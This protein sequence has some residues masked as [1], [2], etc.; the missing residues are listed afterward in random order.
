MPAVPT[1][2]PVANAWLRGFINSNLPGYAKVDVGGAERTATSA[3]DDEP[4]DTWVDTKLESAITGDGWA[5]SIDTSGRVTLSGTS[6]EIIWPDRLGWLM[7][8]DAEPGDSEGT[9]TSITSRFV[10]PGQIPLL[11]AKPL[12]MVSDREVTLEID[13]RMRP[14]A[15]VFGT[16]N[17][18][19]YLLTMTRWA[20]D[21]LITGWCLRGGVEIDFGDAS[22]FSSTNPDGLVSGWVIGIES[23]NHI[24]PS[25]MVNRPVE[26]VLLL[27][28]GGA[29][30]AAKGG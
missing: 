3:K 4:F 23:A 9:V 6:A 16:S 22:V 25:G 8:F 11:G 27:A 28:H 2:W 14:H 7:G 17:V 15:S 26:V 20:Y 5:T 19:R 24:G 21:A 10:P 12:D 29:G 13:R 30:G 1:E 18:W